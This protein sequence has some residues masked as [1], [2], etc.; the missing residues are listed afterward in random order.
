MKDYSVGTYDSYKV[1][2]KNQTRKSFDIKKFA[3]EN[4]NIDLEPYYTTKSSRV[5]RFSR[6]D[7]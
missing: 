6:K 7:K 3:R 5:F 2:W 4:P 1:T